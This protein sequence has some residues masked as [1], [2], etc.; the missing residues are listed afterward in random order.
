[1]NIFAATE[2]FILRELE[3]T[4]VDALFELDADPEVHRYLRN[5]PVTTKEQIVDVINFIRQQCK[6][7]LCK[8]PNK[9]SSKFL[10]IY[11]GCSSIYHSKSSGY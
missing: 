5:N 2:R 10:R 8:K 9:L 11:I 7:I 1:M 4:D 6:G 3:P